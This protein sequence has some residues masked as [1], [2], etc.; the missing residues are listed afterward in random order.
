MGRFYHAVMT[1]WG[2][3]IVRAACAAALAWGAPQAAVAEAAV[4]LELILAVDVSASVSND[5]YGLQMGGIAS[6]FRH[7]EVLAA[8]KGV[9]A[10]GIAVTLV[11]WSAGYQQQQTVPWHHVADG[12]SAERLAQAI[13]AAP[14]AFGVNTTAIGSAL[15][16]CAALFADN[17]YVGRRL[18]IDVSGDGTNNSGMG[19]STMRDQ[20][21]ATGITVN[22]LAILNGDEDLE[23]Y[24][25]INVI[26]GPRSFVDTAEDFA[27]F[28]RAIRDK[29]VREIAPV[30]VE[31]PTVAPPQRR[32][33][34]C[35][36]CV[37]R[38]L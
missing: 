16:F 18:T 1:R 8:I 25:R 20:V 24:Y 3:R 36:T 28:A 32:G 38:R 31:A 30:V 37:R 29:L 7:P 19:V 9:G 14:R 10:G 26:G 4:E 11:Q 12:D 6:A 13:E 22:G 5:E 33:A 23:R 15:K 34:L 21:V 27:D 17:Q 35:A 2:A